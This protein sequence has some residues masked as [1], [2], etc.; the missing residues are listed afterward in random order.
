MKKQNE[1]RL[2]LSKTNSSRNINLAR[3]NL[4][5]LFDVRISEVSYGSPT[6]ATVAWKLEMRAQVLANMSR[7]SSDAETVWDNTE[8]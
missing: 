8:K 7:Q 5:F 4:V 3:G 6:S 2:A 1:F